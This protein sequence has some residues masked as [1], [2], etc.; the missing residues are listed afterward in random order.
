MTKLV[1]P[2]GLAAAVAASFM[3]SANGAEYAQV[4]SATPV[5]SS[6]PTY[7][8]DCIEGDR[9]VQTRP[10]GAGALNG[11]IAGGG[12]GN[13]FGHGFGR[14]AASCLSDVA[15]LTVGNN[16]ES[17]TTSTIVPVRRCRTVDACERRIVGYDVR[18]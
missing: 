13:Q 15:G 2:S 3:A 5:R 14:A 7:R 8:Q 11:A 12:V 9:V 18:L 17:N 4:I 6:V 10:S 16:V 1:A